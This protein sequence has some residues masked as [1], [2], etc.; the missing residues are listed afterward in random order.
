MRVNY[1]FWTNGSGGF[2][3]GIWRV[4][5]VTQII[6]T[7]AIGPMTVYLVWDKL[8]EEQNLDEF[9]KRRIRLTNVKRNCQWWSTKKNIK[10]SDGRSWYYKMG[11]YNELL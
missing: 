4:D 9:I 2:G 11:T 1:S 7:I 6:W 8:T 10:H 5:Y 3:L